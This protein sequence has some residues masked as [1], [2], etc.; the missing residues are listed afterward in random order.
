V[1]HAAWRVATRIGRIARATPPSP[2]LTDPGFPRIGRHFRTDGR[3][4]PRCHAA[5][6]SPSNEEGHGTRG[7]DQKQ[8]DAQVNRT[9]KFAL[10][11]FAGVGVF[12]AIVM[13]TIALMQSTDSSKTTTV[14]RTVGAAPATQSLPTSVSGTIE[15]VTKGCHTLN[16]EGMAQSA[17]AATV[18]LAVGGTL[19]LQ[20]N[21]V[22]PHKLFR[23]SGPQPS[24]TNADM[25]RM[26]AAARSVS[27]PRGLRPVDEGRRGLH[28]GHQDDR[29]GQHAED[30]RVV[31]GAPA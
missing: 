27:M 2:A 4:L 7:N 9:G 6:N 15:H 24:F 12:A 21:D 17:P 25:T 5:L 19:N 31:G 29:R 1:G 8:F 18:H 28:E 23:V 3:C 26:G 10:E 22:M 16:I 13:S 11:I 30:P 14:I 20:D